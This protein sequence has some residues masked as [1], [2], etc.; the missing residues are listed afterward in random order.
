MKPFELA[1]V[2]PDQVA[3]TVLEY[4]E[5]WR[6]GD[7]EMRAAFPADTEFEAAKKIRETVLD[8]CAGEVYLNDVYQVHR[9]NFGEM[10]HL[11]IKR[12]DKQPIHD[13]RDLQEIK[14]RLVG[15]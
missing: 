3:K 2:P 5:L 8:L 1:I 15:C 12:V 6:Q 9:R 7:A 11:S 10:T 13:W 14:N 4:T